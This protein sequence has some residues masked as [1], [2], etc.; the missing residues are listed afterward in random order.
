MR[1]CRLEQKRDSRVI[2]LIHR[3]GTLS[4]LGFPLARYVGIHDLYQAMGQ[5]VSSNRSGVVRPQPRRGTIEGR[6]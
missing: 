4:F 6:S 3:Q 5:E 2:A 1:L